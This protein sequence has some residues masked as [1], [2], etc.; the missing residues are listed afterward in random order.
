MTFW[1]QIFLVTGD[2]TVK[3]DV[4]RIMDST[5]KHYGRLDVLINN[6]GA[7]RARNIDTCTIEDLDWCYNV[8]VR[9]VFMMSKAA[10]PHLEK[11]K[12]AILN[13][14]SLAGLRPVSNI[15]YHGIYP[16]SKNKSLTYAYWVTLFNTLTPWSQLFTKKMCL[17]VQK[18]PFSI[19]LKYF[20]S[21]LFK[22]KRL[23]ISS[24]NERCDT[25]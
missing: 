8:L 5:V 10:I 13:M 16:Q 15:V 4:E 11:T 24:H 23:G 1:V 17:T 21:T 14:S 22:C 7:T 12:G 6:A 20:P 9:S 18:V 19:C 2:V 25:W 3:E